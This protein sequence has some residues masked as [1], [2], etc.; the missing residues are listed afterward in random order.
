MKCKKILITGSTGFIG[1]NLVMFLSKQNYSLYCLYRSHRGDSGNNMTYIQQ[2]LNQPLVIDKL[3]HDVDCIIHLAANMSKT[4]KNSELF[5]TNTVGTL[6][7]LEYGKTTGIKKFIFASTGGVYGYSTS[8][9][10]EESRINPVDF[11]GL[12]KYESELLVKHY[13]KHFSTTILRLFFPYGRGQTKNII[14]LLV[15]RIKNNEPIIIYNDDNPKINP[16]YITDVLNAISNSL[17]LEGQDIL[18]IAG[19]DTITI[20]ELAKLISTHIKSEPIFKYV[21]DSSIV[22]LVGD[23]TKMR[24]ILGITPITIEEGIKKYLMSV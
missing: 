14:P 21:D 6:N 9:H 2:D 22:D 19:N 7:L 1:S 17:L 16:I 5:Q 10:K 13:S 3:P 11:Y 15:N 24:K 8:P 4:A 23:N 18:N 20:K 12:S